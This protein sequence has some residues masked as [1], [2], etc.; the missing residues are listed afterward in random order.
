MAS[1]E[2][3]KAKVKK[4][5]SSDKLSD[6]SVSTSG[7]L[8]CSNDF[9][10]ERLYSMQSDISALALGPLQPSN[11]NSAPVRKTNEVS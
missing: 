6:L 5:Y 7:K 4:R 9:N 3:T 2:E 1:K 8:G 10:R 11:E